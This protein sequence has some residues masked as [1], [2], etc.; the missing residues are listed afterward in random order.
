[1]TLAQAIMCLRGKNKSQ[2]DILVSFVYCGYNSTQSQDMNSWTGTSDSFL[3]S[4]KGLVD[5]ISLP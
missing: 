5:M 1:M 2:E 3:G 4:L